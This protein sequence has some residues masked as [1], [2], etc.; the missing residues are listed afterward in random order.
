MLSNT[1][2]RH[3]AIKCDFQK[4][5]SVLFFFPKSSFFFLKC[6]HPARIE[7]ESHF[8]NLFEANGSNYTVVLVY[9]QGSPLTKSV[10]ELPPETLVNG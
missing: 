2:T 4:T 3:R 8:P 6:L 1:K 10:H 9:F 7:L 5:K